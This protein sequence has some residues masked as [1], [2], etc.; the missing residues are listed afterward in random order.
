VKHNARSHA[1]VHELALVV[2]RPK[3]RAPR[4]LQRFRCVGPACEDHCCAGWQNVDVDLETFAR[5]QDVDDAELGPRLRQLVRRNPEPGGPDELA[6]ISVPRG[7][8][9]PLF[10]EERLCSVQLRL[11]E[12]L[13]PAS[14]DTFPRQATLIDGVLE[15][16][17]RFA[18]PEVVR[19]ALLAPDALEPEE[20]APDRRIAERGRFWI[21]RPWTE[22]PA[23]DPR[24]Y[25]HR[26]RV[27]A[28]GAL[29]RRDL[30]LRT[31]LRA[32]GRALARLTEWTLTSPKQVE[33]AFA[34]AYTDGSDPGR[35][36][37][38]PAPGDGSR[39][40]PSPLLLERV[41]V[42]IAMG[43]LPPRYRACVE[44]VRQGLGLPPGA[45]EPIE[46][47]TYE[48]YAVAREAHLVPYLRRRPYVLEHALLN[49][50]LL[51]SFPFHPVRPFLEEYALLVCR[52]GLL[53]LH[54]VGAAAAEGGLTD[55]LVV[56]T[57]QA[58]DK[59]ADSADYWDRTLRLLR[60][61]DALGLATIWG[62]MDG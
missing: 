11:G 47:Q 14:C 46:P 28:A 32:L 5:Y 18:C 37:E 23:D 24:R 59:Y 60:R 51:S 36:R 16:G 44:R 26:V 48:R 7:G 38:A 2:N 56:E 25:Y 55:A 19:L 4:Y 42:W 20:M 50:I 35:P 52:F 41:R 49:H 21:E 58:F 53:E 33:S 17:G 10:T 57:V 54:L 29:R 62:L 12:E 31:R 3:V 30:E 43:N 8:C 6:L 22:L 13:L 15:V 40:A 45:D 1:P 61:S 39:L 9:C 34:A 27:L